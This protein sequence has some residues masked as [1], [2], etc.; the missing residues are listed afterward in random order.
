MANITGR[1]RRRG[2]KLEAV[3]TMSVK[4]AAVSVIGPSPLAVIIFE[5]F[6]SGAALFQNLTNERRL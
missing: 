2:T 5:I 4:L 1:I 3:I 6:Q